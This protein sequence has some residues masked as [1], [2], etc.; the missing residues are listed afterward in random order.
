[1]FEIFSN[2][3]SN[4]FTGK[5]GW[6]TP[7]AFVLQVI[8]QIY[9]TSM[10]GLSSGCAFATGFF[11]VTVNLLIGFLIGMQVFE[12]MGGKKKEAEEGPG[13]F[14]IIT[15]FISLVFGGVLNAIIIG[16]AWIWATQSFF[17]AYLACVSGATLVHLWGVARPIVLVM[18]RD[19]LQG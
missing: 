14:Y 7:L 13:A 10:L 17:P 19:R 8:L 18:R 2:L 5:F 3:V 15:L 6:R 12:G 16:V 1:M 4:I 9:V 11:L